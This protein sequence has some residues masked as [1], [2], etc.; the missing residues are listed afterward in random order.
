M[1]GERAAEIAPRDQPDVVSR[2]IDLRQGLK[3][4]EQRGLV[5]LEDER[6]IPRIR[7]ITAEGVWRGDCVAQAR[8]DVVGE[9]FLE[10]FGAVSRLA[11]DKEALDSYAHKS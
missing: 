6:H 8:D 11:T 1:K 5:T 10:S 9:E 7:A 4:C 3:D 2:R